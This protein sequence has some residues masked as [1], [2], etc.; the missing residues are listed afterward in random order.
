MGIPSS[1]GRAAP[2]AAGHSINF[3][4]AAGLLAPVTIMLALW[5]AVAGLVLAA[6]W[7]STRAS[8]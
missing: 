7:T 1:H 6:R 8:R 4:L 2:H 3:Y 5:G